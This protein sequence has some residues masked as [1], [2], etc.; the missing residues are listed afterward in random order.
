M[1]SIDISASGLTAQR[2]RMDLIAENL[3]NADT[4][5]TANG[6][7][8]QRLQAVLVA[9]QVDGGV[10]VSSIAAD[11]NMPPKVY[12]PGHPDADSAGFV[13]MPNVDSVEEMVDLVTAS[14]IYEAN[15]T[16]IDASKAMTRQALE[17]SR[18]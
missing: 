6:G 3:A 2:V 16:A 9:D 4:T 17:L 14:R 8:Y 11:T 13:Q 5:R 10:K 7:A 12:R 1:S 18:G 15:V